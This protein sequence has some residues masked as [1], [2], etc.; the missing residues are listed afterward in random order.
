[1]NSI[2]AYILYP[3]W[4]GHHSANGS[5]VKGLK[6]TFRGNQKLE[7]YERLFSQITVGAYEQSQGACI[8]SDGVLWVPIAKYKDG[9]D[10]I[11]MYYETSNC[12]VRA[13]GYQVKTVSGWSAVMRSPKAIHAYIT[14]HAL[15][16]TTPNRIKKTLRELKSNE[17]C[18]VGAVR[19]RNA[20]IDYN[21][22][23]RG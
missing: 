15:A 9:Y 4:V 18:N 7:D 13:A 6:A 2:I 22:L 17:Y 11:P 21:E 8:L 20:V 19:I 16:E 23:L 10:E 12:E 14:K 1:M 3:Y 5:V